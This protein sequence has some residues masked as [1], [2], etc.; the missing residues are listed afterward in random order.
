M[1]LLGTG[2]RLLRRA[3]LL[4]LITP[5]VFSPHNKLKI[6]I[7]PFGSP[8]AHLPIIFSVRHTMNAVVKSYSLV[9]F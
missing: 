1:C 8:T 5:D 9:Q 3:K 2:L 7:I 4:P 6:T